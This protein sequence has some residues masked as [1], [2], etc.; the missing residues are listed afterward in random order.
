MRCC[1]TGAERPAAICVPAS[2]DEFW[3][4]TQTGGRQAVRCRRRCTTTA[5]SSSSLG[6]CT[7]WLAPQAEALGV[8]IFPA[9]PPP[10][11]CTTTAGSVIG[12]RIGD[13]GVEKDGT[14]GPELHARHRHPR[15]G[16]R[17][18]RRRR[19]SLTK[20]LVAAFELD[21]DCD[22]QAYR[23]ASRSCG[24]L[25]PGRVQP[26]LDRAH[27][28]AGRSTRAPTAAASCITST[29]TASYVGYVSGLDYARSANTSRS[30]RSSSSRTIRRSSRCSKA[31][32]SSP[33]ARA[34][35]SP[36][37][38]SRCRSSRCPARC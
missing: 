30:K 7:P 32:R 26:G 13:M 36:A 8:E 24:S 17:A 38:G 9:S 10:R 4:L 35:S 34:R 1:P 37:A 18:R 19:G 20:Q 2:D 21:A 27:A 5:I 14:P 12:V 29:A 15:Q 3:L 23:S 6:G 31:A 25:P 16:H 28:S 33:P 11:R 22:P